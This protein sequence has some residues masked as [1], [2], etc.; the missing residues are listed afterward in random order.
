MSP[1]QRIS[2]TA[3]R[4]LD[5]EYGPGIYNRLPYDLYV[6]IPGDNFSRLKEMA[7]SAKHYKW[8]LDNPRKSAP[9]SLGKAAHTAVLEPHRF[10]AEYALWDERTEDDK[11]RPRRGKVWEEFVV[12]NPGKQIVRADEHGLAMS[13]RDEVRSNPAAMKYL[14][15]GTPETSMVWDDAETGRRCKGRTDWLVN[16]DGIDCLV[17]LKTARDCRNIWFGNAAA[18]LGYHLQ[19]AFYRDGYEA[20]SGNIPRVVEIVIESAPPHDLVVYI[21]PDEIVELGRDEYRRH[22]VTLGECETADEW[23]GVA[24]EEQIL[25]YPSYMYQAEEDLTDIGLEA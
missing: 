16:V 10:A 4:L 24:T 18:R 3:T 7:R 14:R 13:M 6:Q 9:I 11:V 25:S 22:L 5:K 15:K 12:A 21:I 8:R 23:P 17:G 1:T 20:L 2:V 19:W